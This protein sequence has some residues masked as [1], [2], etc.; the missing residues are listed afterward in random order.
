MVRTNEIKAQMKRLGVTQETLARKM[1]MNPS[2]LNRKINS[3]NGEKIT[4]AEALKLADALEFP[5]TALV[6]IFFAQELAETQVKTAA[7]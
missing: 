2:T 3:E 7:V 4:V 5:R 6:G 1:K